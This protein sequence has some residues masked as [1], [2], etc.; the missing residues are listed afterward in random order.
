MLHYTGARGDSLER[1]RMKHVTFKFVENPK[2]I[3]GVRL[4]TEIKITKDKNVETTF[5]ILTIYGKENH[6]FCPCFLLL[7]YLMNVR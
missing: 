5:R 3:K 1:I 7:S 4:I 6:S 2:A